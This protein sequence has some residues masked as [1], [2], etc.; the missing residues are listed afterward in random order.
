MSQ[1]KRTIGDNQHP[2]QERLQTIRNRYNLIKEYKY[3]KKDGFRY[4]AW[5]TICCLVGHLNSRVEWANNKVF[6]YLGLVNYGTKFF[7]TGYRIGW[8]P[9]SF[10]KHTWFKD[11]I[12]NPNNGGHWYDADKFGE[13]EKALC[14]EL[15]VETEKVSEMRVLYLYSPWIIDAWYKYSAPDQRVVVEVDGDEEIETHRFD[16]GVRRKKLLWWECYRVK[17]R[18]SDD[19]TKFDRQCDEHMTSG[20]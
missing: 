18:W 19:M 7:Q 16:G 1:D 17:E 8:N 6:W 5:T 15:N 20:H 3:F 13:K 2:I 11:I 12:V 10:L 9:D 4:P 14:K